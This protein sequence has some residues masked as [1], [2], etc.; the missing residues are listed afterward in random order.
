MFYSEKE[1]I[2]KVKS[3]YSS[4]DAV[5]YATHING[6]ET[7]PFGEQDI[8][9]ELYYSGKLKKQVCQNNFC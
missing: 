2:D 1:K 8:A 6:S 9:Y 5:I 4:G 3:L 7:P